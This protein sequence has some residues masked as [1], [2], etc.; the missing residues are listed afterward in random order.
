[1]AKPLVLIVI[2]G[3]TPAMLEAA[4]E[5]DSAPA[6]RFLVENGSYGTATSVFPSLTPVCLSSIATGAFPDVHGIPHLVWW[7]AEERRLVEYGSSFAA[8]AFVPVLGYLVAVI[9]PA[10]A[11]RLRARAGRTYA[12]LRILARD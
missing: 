2:D 11:V 9:V 4:V 8:I 10:V 6:L 12:G 1:M 3:L 5:G 7:N